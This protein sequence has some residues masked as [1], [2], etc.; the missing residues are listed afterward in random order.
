MNQ[1]GFVAAASGLIALVCGG[2]SVSDGTSR[3]ELGSGLEP[4]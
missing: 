4:C 1:K 2:T 3:N